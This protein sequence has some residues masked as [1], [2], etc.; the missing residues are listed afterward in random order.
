MVEGRRKPN[1]SI[2]ILKRIFSKLKIFQWSK[3]G[4]REKYIAMVR[5]MNRTISL[6]GCRVLSDNKITWWSYSPFVVTIIYW[7]LGA[8]TIYYHTTNNQFEKALPSLCLFGI[9]ISVCL[10]TFFFSKKLC[11]FVGYCRLSSILFVHFE[12]D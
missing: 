5:F 10:S 11:I 8:F 3:K 7:S 2:A 9:S 1:S 4:S 12:T 6:L